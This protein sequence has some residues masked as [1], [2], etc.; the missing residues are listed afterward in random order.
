[1]QLENP[2]ERW[3]LSPPGSDHKC[4]ENDLAAGADIM[5]TNTFGCQPVK[6]L[7]RMGEPKAIVEA[8]AANAR[9][10]VDEAGRGF[11]AP[12]SGP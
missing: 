12:G 5:T 8:A 4:T 2:P 3:N 1:M 9:K 7:T 11:V 10:A 6:I